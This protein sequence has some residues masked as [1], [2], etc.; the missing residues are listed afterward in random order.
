MS[1]LYLSTSVAVADLCTNTSEFLVTYKPS[2]LPADILLYY[3]QCDS[4]RA[5]PFTQRI[6]EILNAIGNARNSMNVV[7]R[8]SLF[9]F[10]KSGLNPKLGS[11]QA[12]TT[13]QDFPYITN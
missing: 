2:S 1:G 5:N 7:S 11:L 8:Y 6:R 9:L 10:P 3:T 4:A 13:S 12:G